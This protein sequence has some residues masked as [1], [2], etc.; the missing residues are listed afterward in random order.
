MAR[1]QSISKRKDGKRFRYWLTKKVHHVGERLQIPRPHWRA[2]SL[3]PV[4][5]SSLNS[6]ALSKAFTP[7]IGISR[8]LI[9]PPPRSAT[10]PPDST[11][12]PAHAFQSSPT[13]TTAHIYTS[14]TTPP[15]GWMHSSLS[16]SPT[17]AISSSASQPVSNVAVSLKPLG[18][19]EIRGLTYKVLKGRLS[20]EE[21]VTLRWDQYTGTTAEQAK[22]VVEGVKNILNSNQFRATK[23]E[24]VLQ[25]ADKYC[26]IIDVAIQHQPDITALVWAGIRMSIQVCMPVTE[27]LKHRCPLLALTAF[28]CVSAV[29]VQLNDSVISRGQ[30]KD[31]YP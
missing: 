21:L 16:T 11:H 8:R 18:Q 1:N 14:A 27:V 7:S 25:Y 3:S 15:P 6:A 9:T 24:K 30:D 13:V 28:D 22:E 19:T 29:C 31:S 23:I 26:K 4:P 17:A 5:E 10:S 2:R 20:P 12:T